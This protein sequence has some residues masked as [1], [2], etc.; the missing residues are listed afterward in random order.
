MLSLAALLIIVKKENTHTHT[1]TH[2]RKELQCPKVEVSYTNYG[3]GTQ[4]YDVVS[5]KCF[6][7]SSVVTIPYMQHTIS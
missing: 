1:H 6:F 7:K 2:T 4:E 3:K 5:K